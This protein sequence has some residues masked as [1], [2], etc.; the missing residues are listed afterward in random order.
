MLGLALAPWE[1]VRAEDLVPKSTHRALGLTA[2][3]LVASAAACT[4]EFL[5]RAEYAPRRD[6]VTSIPLRV[7]VDVHW[8]DV[9]QFRVTIGDGWQTRSEDLYRLAGEV[10]ER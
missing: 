10:A 5:P 6:Q 3:V 2:L 9:S 4:P 7:D 8:P 1:H